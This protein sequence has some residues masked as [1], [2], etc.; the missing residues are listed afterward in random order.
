M[1]GCFAFFCVAVL[2]AAGCRAG[3]YAVSVVVSAGP[4]AGGDWSEVDFGDY[5]DGMSNDE[6]Y[7]WPNGISS[8]VVATT[9]SLYN[10]GEQVSG[11]FGAPS[12]AAQ[13]F[14]VWTVGTPATPIDLYVFLRRRHRLYELGWHGNP[15]DRHLVVKNV[16]T[17]ATVDTFEFA[18]NDPANT[19]LSSEGRYQCRAGRGDRRRHQLRWS[20]GC[21]QSRW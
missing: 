17:G 9:P 16:T 12:T 15:L 8:Y 5:V 7:N 6:P 19:P 14:Y 11:T 21:T 10:T 13:D 20:T 3:A 2:L 4:V 18:G 1:K